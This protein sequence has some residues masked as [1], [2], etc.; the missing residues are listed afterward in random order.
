[1]KRDQ[2]D[3]YLRAYSKEEM[4]V[5][6]TM[7]AKPSGHQT[8]SVDSP[9]LFEDDHFLSEGENIGVCKNHRFVDVPPHLHNYIELSYVWSGRFVQFINGEK[10]VC[11][12]GDVCILDT[13]TV[14][15]IEMS[16][17]NDI[18]IN[19]LMRKEFFDYAFL[20]RLTKQGILAEFLVE[21]VAKKRNRTSYLLFR[22]AEDEVLR[23]IVENI[24]SEYYSKDFGMREMLESYMVILFTQLLRYYKEYA[25]KEEDSVNSKVL[26][27]LDYIEKNHQ[28]CTLSSMARHFGFNSGYLTTL[29]KERTGKSFIEHVHDQKLGQAKLLLA[30]TN[31]TV[32]EIV[33]QCGYQNMSYFYK[34]FKESEGITPAE[35]RQKANIHKA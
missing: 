4:I 29:L 22:T 18:T 5:L 11:H 26:K 14:H 9:I 32:S 24:L 1:M 34:K 20:G 21:A 28:H 25:V 8:N 31:T 6:D 35:F 2:V 17:E 15:S 12:K 7:A 3:D 27:L 19:I 10:I 30:N 33:I 23:Q 13:R 16:Q